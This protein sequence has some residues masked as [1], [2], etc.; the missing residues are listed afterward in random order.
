MTQRLDNFSDKIRARNS[1]R[2]STLQPIILAI[3]TTVGLLCSGNQ[4]SAAENTVDSK[5]LVLERLDCDT[6]FF[7]LKST[8]ELCS[9]ISYFENTEDQKPLGDAF[10]NDVID[11]LSQT[12]GKYPMTNLKLRE[13]VESLLISGRIQISNIYK[14]DENN[15]SRI[16]AFATNIESFIFPS[17]KYNPNWND[18]P[19]ANIN[20]YNKYQIQVVLNKDSKEFSLRKIE[21]LNTSPFDGE[22]KIDLRVAYGLDSSKTFLTG[23]SATQYDKLQK[24]EQ[25]LVDAWAQM[26][27]LASNIA[28]EEQ[29]FAKLSEDAAEIDKITKEL[30][31]LRARKLALDNLIRLAVEEKAK[32][33]NSIKSAKQEIPRLQAKLNTIIAYWNTTYNNPKGVPTDNE[34]LEAS[35]DYFSSQ[36]KAPVSDP[37][38]LVSQLSVPGFMLSPTTTFQ[39]GAFYNFHSI[40]PHMQYDWS[41]KLTVVLSENERL[42]DEIK[43][44][45]EAAEYYAQ[46]FNTLANANSKWD[47]IWDRAHLR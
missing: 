3:A 46:Q 7:G 43:K 40:G 38:T 8:P 34:I 47:L 44:F 24:A 22:Y 26:K 35:N 13:I 45:K 41:N 29:R 31:D 9:I 32:L 18:L 20:D 2:L 28:K 21:A 12:D 23:A 1:E 10:M 33:R 42:R 27:L 19:A 15:I 17:Y 36:S 5:Q 6:W 37:S 4:S 16:E 11:F 39:N 25:M 30:G 14:S